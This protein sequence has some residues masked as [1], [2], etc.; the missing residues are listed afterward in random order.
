MKTINTRMQEDKEYGDIIRICDI[1]AIGS[2]RWRNYEPGSRK[3]PEFNIYV[4]G[5][6]EPLVCYRSWK[7]SEDRSYRKTEAFRNEILEEWVKQ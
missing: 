6:P 5:I 3:K 7:G 1:R 2:I 4:Q